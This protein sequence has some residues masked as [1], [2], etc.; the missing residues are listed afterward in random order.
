MEIPSYSY[1]FPIPPCQLCPSTSGACLFQ[2]LSGLYLDSSSE[3]LTLTSVITLRLSSEF[4]YPIPFNPLYAINHYSEHYSE[5]G[6]FSAAF[7]EYRSCFHR[8]L[9]NLI[10]GLAGTFAVYELLDLQTKEKNPFR[11]MRTKEQALGSTHTLGRFSLHSFF[12]EKDLFLKGRLKI[13]LMPIVHLFQAHALPRRFRKQVAGLYTLLSIPIS[14]YP[15]QTHY[16][17]SEVNPRGILIENFTGI[18][19]PTHC[20]FQLP[21]T[22]KKTIICY[23]IILTSAALHLGTR[24]IAVLIR[25]NGP[26]K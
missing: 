3:S 21:G 23:L 15:V 1:L 8:T 24:R 17:L 22:C 19:N 14:L 6:F 2:L 16:H 5:S 10:P 18:L 4:C 11:K 20:K 26:C 12:K 9:K 25:H 13:T 7:Q